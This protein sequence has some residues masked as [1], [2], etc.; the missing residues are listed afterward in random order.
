VFTT[1]DGLAVTV[2]VLHAEKDVWVRFAVS[3]SSDKAKTEAAR[4]NGRVAGWTYQIGSWKEKSLVPTIDDLK[5]EEPAK[6]AAPDA[7]KK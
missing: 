4:I 6:P 7:D 2:T 5:A 3:G 1:D